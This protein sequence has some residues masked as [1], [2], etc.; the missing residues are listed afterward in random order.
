LIS[1][2]FKFVHASARCRKK[3]KF[4]LREKNSW[5]LSSMKIQSL[6]CIKF[7]LNFIIDDK[8]FTSTLLFNEN[9]HRRNKKCTLNASSM[10]SNSQHDSS[11]V[12]IDFKIKSCSMKSINSS[13]YDQQQRENNHHDSSYIWSESIQR[14]REISTVAHKNI[15]WQMILY[16]QATIMIEYASED[17]ES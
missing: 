14:K 6:M 5:E 8:Q 2:D 7:T 12:F 4:D 16:L 10:L 11:H 9:D 15:M 17:C 3:S 13:F 1:N